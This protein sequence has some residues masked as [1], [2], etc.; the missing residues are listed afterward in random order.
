[1]RSLESFYVVRLPVWDHEQEARTHVDFPM[2]LPHE[3]VAASFA[4]DPRQFDPINFDADTLPPEFSEH[5][6]V[7]DAPGGR[8]FPVGFYS[9]AVPHTRSDS[10]IAYYL[11]NG[12]NGRR[13]LLCSLRKSDLCKCGCK[14]FCTLGQVMRV[15]T[16]SFCALASGLYP[17]TNHENGPLDHSRCALRGTEICSGWRGALCEIRADLLEITS[18]LGFRNWQNPVN[19][20]FVCSCIKRDLYSFPATVAQ[21]VWFP[22]DKDAYRAMVRLALKTVT[23]AT[24]QMLTGLL[25][26]ARFD[27][28][29]GGYAVFQQY[30]PLGLKAGYRLIESG[31]VRDL[32]ALHELVLPARLQFFD[33]GNSF[34]LNLL[35]SLFTVPGVTVE[36]IHLDAMHIL[37]LGVSQ[38]LI[39]M[40]LCLL[41]TN[42]FSQ[43]QKSTKKLR[44][45][46]GLLHLRRR[47]RAYYLAN[48]QVTSKI[49]KISLKMFMPSKETAHPRLRAKAA[50]TRWLVPLMPLLCR[51][52]YRHL[53]PHKA[54]LFK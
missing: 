51:E 25:R 47:I 44:M 13:S 6:V 40:I 53:G 18:S 21:S 27:D 46:D 45:H 32:H 5:S 22:R 11:S 34:G 10:F 7:R 48:P 31:Q 4:E 15:L 26:C 41:L 39:G 3:Q 20:C 17:A 2:N 37:D 33:S 29:Y 16:W 1:V 9:D 49:D 42:N 12:L 36:C 8:A 35:C 28:D 52:S 38:Y 43:S 19:P 14:G 23:V 54:K 24:P 50:E 30:A